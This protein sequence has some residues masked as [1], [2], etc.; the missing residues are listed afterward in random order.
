[1]TVVTTETWMPVSG[2]FKVYP[3]DVV[4]W[5][6]EMGPVLH[7]KGHHDAEAFLAAAVESWADYDGD[8]MTL[9]ID[10]AP[11]WAQLEGPLWP[12]AFLRDPS[13]VRQEWWANRMNA[14]VLAEGYAYCC[15]PGGPARPGAYPVTVVYG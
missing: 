6:W 2:R 3:L 4:Y 11:W 10:V 13:N 12:P 7:S 8:A 15:E 1:M 9:S 5:S 14:Q